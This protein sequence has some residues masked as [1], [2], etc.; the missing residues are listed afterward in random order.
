MTNTVHKSVL[1]SEA[2]DAL[3]PHDGG[4]YIDGTLGGGG[5]TRAL[6]DASA[7][8]GRVLSFD[9][10][11]LALRRATAM[12]ASYGKRWIGI[13]E[14]F[15]NIREV[16]ET[17][18]FDSCDGVLFDLGISSDQLV[19][20]LKGLSFQEDGPLDMRLG[21]RANEDGLTASEIV[22]CWSR[23]EIE[24]LLRVFGE[25]RFARRIADAIE[26][27]R[28]VARIT[29]TLDLS[30]VVRKAVPDTF[31][32]GRIHPA[33]KTFMA[34]RIAVNDELETL[35]R[36]IEGSRTILKERGRI[37][38]ITFH[39]LDD[40][41]V[42]HAFRDAP[43]LIA[44]TKKP[45]IPTEDEVRS[46]PRAR[47]AKLRIAEKHTGPTLSKNATQDSEHRDQN[48]IKYGKNHRIKYDTSP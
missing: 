43:D 29:R 18:G 30:A 46:N 39:S 22:N 17:R 2:L 7:P 16:A 23:D 5:H 45:L 33:T 1:Q 35:K 41:I 4:L 8:T 40:R 31:R 48:Q 12:F 37:A 20:P 28:S 32:R 36:A 11:P 42:K 13:E 25:E 44:I 6:L 21:P 19:D 9:L 15:R 26:E 24:K 34:L 38:I 3:H 27:A 10:D 47:S 14:N